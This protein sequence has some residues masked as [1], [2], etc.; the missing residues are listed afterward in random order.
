MKN[1]FYA[2]VTKC[3]HV[4]R[5][6]Y[7]EVTFPINAKSGKEAAEIARWLPRVKHH[8]K[9]AIVRV[10]EIDYEKYKVLIEINHN[11]LYLNC[12][13]IQEQNMYCSNLY[14]EIKRMDNEDYDNTEK[15]MARV[16]YKQKKKRVIEHDV[17]A[18]FRGLSYETSYAV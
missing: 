1:K 10:F 9:D 16:I 4:G 13:N 14:L 5:N 17:K 18:Y 12:K 11:D 15:R 7:R 6:N 8:K 2:V 3:G